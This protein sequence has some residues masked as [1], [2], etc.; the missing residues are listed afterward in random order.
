MSPACPGA[1][2][3]LYAVKSNG[4][5]KLRTLGL[6]L[7]ASWSSSAQLLPATGPQVYSFLSL[8]PSLSSIFSFCLASPHAHPRAPRVRS[9]LFSL[10]SSLRVEPT[11]QDG[12]VA[13]A[14]VTAQM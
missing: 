12:G 5:C 7:P 6:L 9:R 14:V 8:S 1:A 4:H 11:W 13:R 3:L 2:C 10:Q